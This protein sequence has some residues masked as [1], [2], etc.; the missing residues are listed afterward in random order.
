MSKIN[1]ITPVLSAFNSNKKLDIGANKYMYERLIN[2]GMD[3]ILVM[4][5]AGEFFGMSLAERKQLIDLAINYQ[6]QIKLIIGTGALTTQEAVD[7]SKYAADAG[8]KNIIVIG[9]YYFSFSEDIL[10]KYFSEIADSVSCN[11]YIYNF[12]ARTGYDISPDLVLKLIQKHSNIVGLKDTVSDASHTRK[13]IQKIKPIY[14]DFEIYSGIDENF[15]R[16]ILS[17]GD[18]AIGALSNIFPRFFSRLVKDLHA[19]NFASV[20]HKQIIIDQLMSLYDITD[21]FIPIFKQAMV[22]NKVNIPRF[23]K[24]P[25]AVPSHD[26]CRQIENII[27]SLDASILE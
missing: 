23:C 4:G 12:P 8:A 3:G 9:P 18:G 17:G 20:Q 7:L 10:Y 16:N 26:Q 24:S 15:T 14:P 22:L 1:Y 5:S 6:D 27:N 25:L 21:C 19:N 13:L 11:V 2:A